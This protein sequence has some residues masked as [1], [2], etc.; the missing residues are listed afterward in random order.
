MDFAPVIE[1][2]LDNCGWGGKADKDAYRAEELIVR[3]GEQT[4]PALRQRLHSSEDRDRRVAV[5]LLVRVEPFSP[6]LTELLRSRLADKDW[7]VRYAAIQ[8]L[9]AQGPAAKEAISDLEKEDADLN[10]I[11]RVAAR[12]ALILRSAVLRETS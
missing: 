10:Q 12:V 1:P 6:G 2:L 7:E 8:G 3:I 5:K 11:N 4:A 9:G